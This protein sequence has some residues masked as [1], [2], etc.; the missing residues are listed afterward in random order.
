MDLF[1]TLFDGKGT[2]E[3]LAVMLDAHDDGFTLNDREFTL[4][5][6]LSELVEILGEPRAFARP[7]T[8]LMKKAYCEDYHKSPEWFKPRDYYWDNAGIIV[9]TFEQKTVHALIIHFRKSKFVPMT[10]CAFSGTFTINGKPWQE[11]CVGCVSRGK[12][13]FNLPLGEKL[14][15]NVIRHGN[16]N[17]ETSVKQFQLEM[18]DRKNLTFFE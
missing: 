11:S 5:V 9:S 8:E 18:C 10:E 1:R 14:H 2:A 15:M 13:T 6:R 4:P 16:P 17:K 12:G 3:K 7:Y